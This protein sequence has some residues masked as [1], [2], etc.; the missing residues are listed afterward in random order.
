VPVGVLSNNDG[1]TIARSEELKAP[2][3]PM[4][5]PYF[6][7]EEKLEEMGARVL[8]SNYALYGD[9]SQRV[10]TTLQKETLEIERYSIDEAFSTLPALSRENLWRVG[11]KIR[12][13]VKRWLGLLIRVAI[14]P[15]KTLVKVADENAKA[16]KHAGMG[17]GVYVCPEEPELEELLP[18]VSVGD[19]WGIGSAHKE[20]LSEKGVASAAE[21]RALPD[22]CIRQE[23]TVVGVRTAQELRGPPF[24][25]LELVRQEGVPTDRKTLVRPR[26]F[27]EKVS[28]KGDLRQALA[29]HAERAA[30]KLREEGLVAKG[31]KAFITTKRF[32][33]PPY[34]PNG[35]A[36]TLPEHT[37]RAAP[38]VK[39]TRRFLEMIYR[40]GY[41][42]KKAGVMLYDIHPSRPHQESFLGGAST[43]RRSREKR[44]RWTRLDDEAPTYLAPVHYTVRGAPRRP[45]IGPLCRTCG[46]RLSLCRCRP[47]SLI[48]LAEN[49]DDALARF[50]EGASARDRRAPGR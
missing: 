8:S 14:G 12:R 13:R 18:C 19:I 10:T 28:S 37:A 48:Q 5:A 38:F 36:G 45:G 32:G 23:M 29:S 39:T 21:F 40:E 43:G 7:W 49:R 30:E 4:G 22:S 47:T 31:I 20:K 50:R 9:M 34:Y 26:S 35:L 27:G 16:R 33:N 2:G 44:N 15:T 42:C 6:K 11:E 46:L 17:K 24:L 3:V 1:C 25:E 41:R